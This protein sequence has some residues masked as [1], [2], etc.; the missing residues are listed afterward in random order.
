MASKSA[1]ADPHGTVESPLKTLQPAGQ[2]TG[3]KETAS[4]QV[5]SKSKY[6]EMAALHNEILDQIFALLDGPPPSDSRLYG[7][8]DYGLTFSEEANIK[9]CSSVCKRWRRVILPVLFRHPRLLIKDPVVPKPIMRDEHLPLF[10][11][12]DKNSFKSLIK[13]F[14]LSIFSVPHHHNELTQGAYW[15]NNFTEF[16]TKLFEVM[17]P[18]D[19]KIVCSPQVLGVLT[20]C[21]VINSDAAYFEMPYHLLH[22]RRPPVPLPHEPEPDHSDDEDFQQRAPIR[23]S[24]LFKIRPWRALLFNEGSFLRAYKTYDFHQ[25]LVPSILDDLIGGGQIGRAHV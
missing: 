6:R 22:L 23:A 16:W 21:E 25:K 20:C 2:E 14:S 11:F 1:A 4:N 3:S 12:I 7:D 18:L 19:V 17:D 8:P 24:T 5:T 15:S 9:S 13:S 10:D